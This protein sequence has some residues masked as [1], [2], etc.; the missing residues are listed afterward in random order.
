MLLGF[1]SLFLTVFQSPV[2]K[3]CIPKSAA[4]H[5]LPCELPKEPAAAAPDPETSTTGVS[6]S[7]KL[8]H[9]L[10]GQFARRRLLSSAVS[11]CGEK[12]SEL[13]QVFNNSQPGL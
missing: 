3:I 11:T 2:S 6:H 9:F 5:W 4:D 12:V 10:G 7:R 13:A 1:I 8:L